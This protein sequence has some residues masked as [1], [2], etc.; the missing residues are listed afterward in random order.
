MFSSEKE[1]GRRPGALRITK[2][3][4]VFRTNVNFVGNLEKAGKRGF[5]V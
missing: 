5:K 2:G 3:L 1:K 4:V